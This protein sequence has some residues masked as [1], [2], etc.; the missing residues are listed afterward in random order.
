MQHDYWYKAKKNEAHEFI[1]QDVK[2]IK[3]Q[4]SYRYEAY[5]RYW[6]FYRNIDIDSVSPGGYSRLRNWEDQA[7]D[8]PIMTYNVCKSVVDTA[9]SKITV[10]KPRIRYITEG[11]N[12]TE[13]K[14]GQDLTK[15][16]DGQF[17]GTQAYELGQLAFK[18]AGINGTGF[19]YIYREYG[20]IKGENVYPNEIYVNEAE[21]AHGIPPYLHRVKY[22]TKEYLK[23]IYPDL[24]EKIDDIDEND[25]HEETVGTKTIKLVPYVSSWYRSPGMEKDDK[26]KYQPIPGRYVCS[27]PNKTLQDIEYKSN[28]FPF[29]RWFWGE[30]PLGYY[31][32]G[33]IEE[34]E[35]L[36]IRLNDLLHQYHE[37]L[38]LTAKPTI[39][40]EY[41]SEVEKGHIT[42]EICNVV[43]Y[44]GTKPEIR[45]DTAVSPELKA[46][47]E[48]IFTKIFEITGIS[49][50]SAQS[51]N[52]LGPNA[53]GAAFREFKALESER[54]Y[55]IEKR[56]EKS[57]MELADLI[58][59]LTKEEAEENP[60]FTVNTPGRGFLKTIKWKDVDLK[61][62]KYIMQVFSSSFL[63]RTP[64]ARVQKVTELMQSGHVPL[65]IGFSL[66]EFP[67]LEAFA[68]LELANLNLVKDIIEQ[69]SEG[70]YIPPEPFMDLNL[71]KTLVQKSY[72]DFKIKKLGEDKLKLFRQ[73][74][75][76]CAK[77]MEPPPAPQ[78]PLADTPLPPEAAGS[79]AQAAG[80]TGGPTAGTIQ[81]GG[82]PTT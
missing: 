65:D 68:N 46:E 62:T 20:E 13:Q 80:L 31:G 69:L 53:S 42:D 44:T 5:N 29:V 19:T 3:D 21:S 64:A 24:K 66:L 72:I 35:D 40:L 71:S 2:D 8:A 7:D 39:Y 63:P 78:V 67:D 59:D 16:M 55:S 28:K 75:N 50:L 70:N 14:R 60:G 81:P 23:S 74:V 73:F 48:S 4:Y 25:M 36:Q 76:A 17:W 22:V 6:R 37:A 49:K 45:D 77:M 32:T 38:S 57:Y 26:G 54:F 58:L 33:L 41:G 51:K 15:F 9:H 82:L 18:T 79:V 61:E 1:L 56:Y 34:V 12:F 11:G 30:L 27:I 52:E 43:F 10:N 47:I